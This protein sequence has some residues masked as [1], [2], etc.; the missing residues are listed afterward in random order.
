[1]QKSVSLLELQFT[2]KQVFALVVL[3]YNCEKV[4]IHAKWKSPPE[5]SQVSFRFYN[6]VASIALTPSVLTSMCSDMITL[7]HPHIRRKMKEEWERIVFLTIHQESL[8][9]IQRSFLYSFLFVKSF[10]KQIKSIIMLQMQ[11]TANPPTKFLTKEWGSFWTS[12]GYS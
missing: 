6:F 12:R 4:L 8:C 9:V 3:S 10:D 1:M 5:L 11:N 2:C 7:M